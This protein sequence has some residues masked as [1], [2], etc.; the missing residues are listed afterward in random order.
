MRRSAL[1]AGEKNGKTFVV[2]V[3]S[4]RCKCRGC[5]SYGQGEE[6]EEE[7]EEGG[8]EVTL[9]SDRCTVQVVQAEVVQVKVCR[10]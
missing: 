5:I 9:L 10:W 8:P 1:S 2:T 6:D 3:L 4:D 7:K